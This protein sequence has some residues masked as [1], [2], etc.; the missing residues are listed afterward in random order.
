MDWKDHPQ[1][2]GKIEARLAERAIELPRAAPP[3]A[4]YLPTV[5]IGEL[6][7]VSGQICQWNGAI[8]FRG[9]CGQ[10]LDLEQGGQAAR[11]CGLNLIAQVRDALGGD[12]DR[13]VRCVRLCGYVNS[14]P[15]FTDQPRV[16]NGCSDLMVEVF[17]E[18][19]KHARVAV[20]VNALPGDAAVEVEGVFQVK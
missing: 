8:R 13:V 11:L 4:S 18:T 10:E 17:G 12:L 1:M 19:G 9:K 16:M 14:T 7:Y 20:G 5:Q 15:T 3:V 2:P 6:V